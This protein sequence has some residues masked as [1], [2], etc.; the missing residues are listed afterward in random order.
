[1]QGVFYSF[2]QGKK[3]SLRLCHFFRQRIKS[4]DSFQCNFTKKKKIK[5]KFPLDHNFLVRPNILFLELKKYVVPIFTILLPI[6]SIYR[7]KYYRLD[8]ENA[9]RS[10]VTMESRGVVG[11]RNYEEVIAKFWQ[12]NH[13]S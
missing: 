10:V 3:R 5:T 9:I 1:M 6:Y 12:H 2:L 7:L 8:R 13:K 11:T 4:N